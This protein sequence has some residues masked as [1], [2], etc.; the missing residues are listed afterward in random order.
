MNKVIIVTG[1]SSGIGRA[2]CTALQGQGH[3]VYEFSR[4]DIPNNGV[5]HMGVDVSDENAV[6]AAVDEVY[7]RE[8]HIDVLINNAGFGIS[9]VIELTDN[10]DAQRLMDV[11]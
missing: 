11:N 8:G 6:K 4:R 9:G 5:T 1:G 3:R 10:A 7:S 2:A